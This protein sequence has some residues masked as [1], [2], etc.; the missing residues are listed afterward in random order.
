MY[1]CHSIQNTYLLSHKCEI[2]KAI[3]LLCMSIASE[4]LLAPGL[5]F[6]PRTWVQGAVQG[7]IC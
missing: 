7:S 2:K 1:F 6:P 4:L 3:S 5:G